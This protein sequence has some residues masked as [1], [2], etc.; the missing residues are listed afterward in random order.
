MYSVIFSLAFFQGDT[1]IKDFTTSS[2]S[3]E[4]NLDTN[5]LKKRKIDIV[6]PQVFPQRYLI[7]DQYVVGSIRLEL[8]NDDD[9]DLKTIQPLISSSCII[10][11]HAHSYAQIAHLIN[12][13]YTTI[14]GRSL[15]FLGHCHSKKY[16]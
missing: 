5:E 9:Y 2:Y 6:C 16:L 8:R 1:R 14:P 11:K 15:L 3:W 13:T 10:I 7:N 12:K 4:K